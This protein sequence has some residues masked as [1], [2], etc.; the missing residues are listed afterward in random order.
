L[1]DFDVV[2]PFVERMPLGVIALRH[3]GKLEYDPES[4]E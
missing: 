1:L 4:P 3:G 2:S